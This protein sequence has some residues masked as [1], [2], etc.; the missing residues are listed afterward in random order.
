MKNVAKASVVLLV[1]GSVVGFAW[2][3][4]A[5]DS[6]GPAIMVSPRTV[7][8]RSGCDQITV[9]SSIPARIVDTAQVTVDGVDVPASFWADDCGDLVARIGVES[10]PPEVDEF[11]LTLVVTSGGATHEPSAT[12]AVKR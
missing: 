5:V 3:N 11:E 7:V 1:V 8:L 6:D 9:H 10:V 2:A 12:V 4:S